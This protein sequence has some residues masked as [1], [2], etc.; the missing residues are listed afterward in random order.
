VRD[1]SPHNG[2]PAKRLGRNYVGAD[3][4]GER[5]LRPKTFWDFSLSLPS[6]TDLPFSSPTAA[7]VPTPRQ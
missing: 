6:R 4:F 5:L 2:F 1:R 3:L 7:Y